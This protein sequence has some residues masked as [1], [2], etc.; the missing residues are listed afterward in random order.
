MQVYNIA[1]VLSVTLLT[2]GIFAILVCYWLATV[3]LFPRFVRASNRRFDSPGKSFLIGLTGFLPGG[4]GLALAQNGGGL[5]LVGMS[6]LTPVLFLAFAG[7]AGLAQRIGTGLAS[8]ADRN[9]PWKRVLRG[10]IVLVFIMLLPFIGWFLVTGVVLTTGFG[11]AI[12]SLV[13]IRRDRREDAVFDRALLDS[14]TKD[15][16]GPARSPLGEEVPS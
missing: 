11:A 5:A 16:S 2:V 8:P 14:A 6:L 4:L 13:Q 3:A 1:S 12:R 10:G 15:A 9:Q 7:S